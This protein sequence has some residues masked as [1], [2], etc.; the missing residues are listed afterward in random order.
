M[1]DDTAH[2]DAARQ[3]IHKQLTE[4]L[5][6][7]WY[8]HGVAL[9]YRYDQSPIIV[10][11]GS[12]ATVLEPSTYIQT[13]RPGHRAP[14]AWLVDGRSMIDLFGRGF[15]LLR[16]GEKPPDSSALAQVAKRKEMPLDVVDITT[17]SIVELYERPLVLVRP[18]GHCAWRGD[19][20]PADVDRLVDTV[21]GF[22]AP[23]RRIDDA[24]IR[25]VDTA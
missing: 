23:R 1:F 17:T 5:K 21:R 10:A 6:Q 7:E 9:G 16:L 11:D 2:G 20:L 12:P 4:S 8:S 24:G 3:R 13:A 22:V 14:H 25:A 15:V 19:S 18:D